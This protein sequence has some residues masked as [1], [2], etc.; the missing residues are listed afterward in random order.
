MIQEDNGVERGRTTAIDVS[1]GMDPTA[2]GSMHQVSLVSSNICH[3][4]L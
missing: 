4:I 1:Q 2:F 3:L